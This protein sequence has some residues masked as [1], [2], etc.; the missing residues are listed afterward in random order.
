M[1]ASINKR[2][3]KLVCLGGIHPGQVFILHHQYLLLLLCLS[4]AC[5]SSQ[6]ID[7]SE[8]LPIIPRK[9]VITTSK[10]IENRYKTG[11]LNSGFTQEQAAELLHINVR[12]L[13]DYENDVK[14]VPDEIVDAMVE[15]YQV[16]YL[17]YWHL[18]NKNILGKRLP[19]IVEPKTLGDMAMLAVM[20]DDDLGAAVKDMKDAI[21]NLSLDD[22]KRP[23]LN[24]ALKTFG[25]V[26]GKLLSVK[27]YGE[28]I[29]NNAASNIFVNNVRRLRSLD[30]NE[31]TVYM[32]QQE[33]VGT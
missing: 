14:H 26:S 12:T 16:P 9:Q 17:A 27:M 21:P 20:A 31:P 11:R 8:Q 28:Q 33:A 32:G 23:Q 30:K 29:D 18:R 6:A 10:V 1:P 19:D 3:N 13:Y 25:A 7:G 2:L 24:K 5:P 22:S 15:V 4:P